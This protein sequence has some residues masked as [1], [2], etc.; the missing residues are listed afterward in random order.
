VPAPPAFDET[1][2]SLAW[3]DPV[4]MT[5]V[6][7]VNGNTGLSTPFFAGDGAYD[8]MT[9]FN[10]GTYG[11][12]TVNNKVWAVINHNSEFAAA[13]EPGSTIL[14]LSGGLALLARRRRAA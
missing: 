7:A 3:Y 10:L 1:T 14:A 5:F 2:L 12:D 9:D 13:P 8:P 6:N 11:V 4:S